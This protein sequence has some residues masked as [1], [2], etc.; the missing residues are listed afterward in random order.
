MKKKQH[1]TSLVKT[2]FNGALHHRRILLTAS[3]VTSSMVSSNFT[4]ARHS[5]QFFV[6]R[7]CRSRQ[8][9]QNLWPHSS[10]VVGSV[11]VSRQM[12]QTN[13]SRSTACGGVFIRVISSRRSNNDIASRTSLIFFGPLVMVVRLDKRHEYIRQCRSFDS[14]D[15]QLFNQP[16]RLDV[17]LLP[18]P[19][20]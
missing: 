6:L 19:I 20:R 1:L 2:G 15:K 18:Q 16:V 8:P 5:G 12:L 3:A 10:R 11:G 13:C 9:K 7:R 4:G 17:S 14:I